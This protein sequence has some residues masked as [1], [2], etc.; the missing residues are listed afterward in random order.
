[1]ASV[2]ISAGIFTTLITI[3]LMNPMARHTAMETINTIKKPS[4]PFKIRA[5]A[6]R[7]DIPAR[8]PMDKSIPPEII[9]T[10]NPQEIIPNIAASRK[11]AIKLLTWKNLS[12]AMEKKI[13]HPNSAIHTINLCMIFPVSLSLSNKSSVSFHAV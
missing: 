2:A 13:Q 10:V 7:P 1:M 5:D 6:A 12:D 8:E 3:P 4:N 11:M 9:T